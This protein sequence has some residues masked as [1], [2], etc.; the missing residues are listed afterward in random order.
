[1]HNLVP[2]QYQE[3]PFLQISAPR[4]KTNCHPTYHY[5]MLSS[6]KSRQNRYF[7][8]LPIQ[9]LSVQMAAPPPPWI[10]HY[11]TQV[12]NRKNKGKTLKMLLLVSFSDFI[13]FHF[14]NQQIYNSASLG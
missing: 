9:D 4:Y 2:E 11:N 6:Y 10:H 5:C 13:L 3:I 7:L 1:M 14:F 8:F 12:Q